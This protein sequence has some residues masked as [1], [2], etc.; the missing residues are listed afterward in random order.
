MSSNGQPEEDGGDGEERMK[1]FLE[2]V[3]A[4]GDGPVLLEPVDRALD[5]VA[6]PVGGT[7]KAYAAARLPRLARD[8]RSDPALTQIG[9]DGLAGVAHVP[10]HARRPDPR[11]ASPPCHRSPL[12]QRL[13]LSRL[14][15]LSRRQHPGDG[16][17]APLG[18][19]VELGPP[20][21]PGYGRGPDRRPLVP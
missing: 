3:V 19:Q 20:S 15:P 21:P 18:P 16:L 4:G 13:G 10:G 2:F 5:R 12:Q 14:M 7:V 17:A 9:A 11:S 8:D 6:L 1:G